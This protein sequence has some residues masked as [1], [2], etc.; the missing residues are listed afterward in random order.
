MLKGAAVYLR[1]PAPNSIPA[2]PITRYRLLR[3]RAERVDAN[4]RREGEVGI[5][6]QHHA[7]AVPARARDF[8]RM[9]SNQGERPAA[10]A[11][12]F[13]SA[14]HDLLAG[15]ASRQECELTTRG[16]DRLRRVG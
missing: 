13:V 12:R 7:P 10:A 6:A 4:R 15:R 11:V 3:Q 9:R 5:V 1:L 14:A 2:P 8:V 16:V